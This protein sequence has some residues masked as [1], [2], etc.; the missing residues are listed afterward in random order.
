M[1]QAATEKSTQHLAANSD[2]PRKNGRKIGDE[3]L[4]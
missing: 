2:E 3:P 1:I 4:W